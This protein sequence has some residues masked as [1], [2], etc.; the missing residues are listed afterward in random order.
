MSFLPPNVPQNGSLRR[1]LWCVKSR[2]TQREDRRMA[3]DI[4]YN[5]RIRKSPFFDCTVEDGVK[6]FTTYNQMLMP[7]HYGDIEG[8]YWRLIDGV[9]MWDVSVERQVQ[10]A[11]HGPRRHV[12]G[13]R[14]HLDLRTGQSR[15][16]RTRSPGYRVG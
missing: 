12:V 4:S 10:I 6:A 1:K 11:Q 5:A 2:Q 15:T 3:F 9:S 13:D 16:R 8:E 14:R 7:A